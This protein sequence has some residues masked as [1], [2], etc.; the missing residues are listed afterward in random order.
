MWPRET[1]ARSGDIGGGIGSP[2]ARQ[3][4]SGFAAEHCRLCGS[5][6]HEVFGCRAVGGGD[7]GQ[8]ITGA[9]AMWHTSGQVLGRCG[10][11]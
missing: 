3:K 9:N 10:R 11:A 1:M 6:K 7:G 2:Q 5:E 8:R 4:S